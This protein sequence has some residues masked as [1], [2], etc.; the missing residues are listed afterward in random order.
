ML[1]ATSEAELQRRYYAATANGYNEMHLDERDEHGFALAFLGSMLGYFD[2]GSAL[3]IG[4]GT[5]RALTF[6][7]RVKPEMRL[8]GIEPVRELREVGYAAGLSEN[9][10]IP[11]D[12]TRLPFSDGEFDLVCE[13]GALHHIRHPERAVREMLR[14]A[15]KA[16]FISDSN[17]FGHGSRP[18]RI[19]KQALDV[20]G[21]WRVVDFVKTGGKGYTVSEGDGVAYSYSVFNDY[22][23][24]RKHCR[25]LFLLNTR[26]AGKNAYRTASHVALLGIIG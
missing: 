17:N 22:A 12:A 7:K 25:D 9:D 1:D 6:L 4:S 8:V 13:F 2:L 15:R 5:G 24:V 14:V 26:D 10:L 16:I 21:L 23:L 18:L 11:G 20:L 19:V 3:D